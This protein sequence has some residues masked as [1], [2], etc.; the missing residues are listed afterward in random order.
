MKLYLCEKPSQGASVA[1]F[2][3]MTAVHKSKQGYFQKDDVAVTWAVGHI[4]EMNPPEHYEQKLKD[5]WKL[6]LLPV[7]PEGKFDYTIKDKQKRQYK[8]IKSLLKKATV[9][10]IATDPDP[11][12]ERISRTILKYAGYKGSLLRV[13]YSSTDNTA[14]TKAFANPVDAKETEWMNSVSRARAESDWLVGMNITMALSLLEKRVSKQKF[15]GAFRCGR[16]KTPLCMLVLKRDE[17]INNFVPVEHYSVEVKVKTKCGALVDVA[18]QVPSNFLDANK[19]LC[20]KSV[21]NQLVDLLKKKSAMTVVSTNKKEKSQGAPLPY[22]QTSLQVACDKF[23]IDA[24]ETLDACQS[25]YSQPL[26]NQ[27]YPRTDIQYLPTGQHG[28]AKSIIEQLMKVKEFVSYSSLL[29]ASRKSRAWNDKKVDVHHGIIPTEK[30]VNFQGFTE[31]QKIVFTLVAKRY[32]SQFATNYRYEHTEIQLSVGNAIF[33]A[34]CNIPLELGWKAIEK[35]IEEGE[36]TAT[37]PSVSEGDVLD[38]VD[39]KIVTKTTKPPVRYTTSTL[40]EAAA[41]IAKEC[42]D[43]EVKKMLSEADGIGT[44]ATRATMIDD[45]VRSGLLILKGKKLQASSRFIAMEPYIPHELKDPATS[46][47]WERAFNGIK[48][49]KMEVSQFVVMQS[50]YVRKCIEKIKKVP[51][52]ER[53]K[54][55][56]RGVLNEM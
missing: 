56:V 29:D 26:S 35:E 38:I 7:V 24:K 50:N 30:S 44:G 3:G 47:L 51:R 40:A 6:E 18:W 31:K 52:P 21:A 19:R 48:V 23:G 5:G 14:L 53:K 36:V 39:A 37:L 17:A 16:V 46:A 4:F 27:S 1:K 11:E 25:L 22:S 10:I 2:L 8:V 28:D 12:G 15:K 43:P 34:T 41:N 9:V 13:L 49:G 55:G 20:K 32:L 45:C 54:R 33:K 42:D